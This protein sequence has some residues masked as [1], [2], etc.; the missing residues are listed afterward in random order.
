MVYRYS[1]WTVDIVVLDKYW[2]LTVDTNWYHNCEIV[3][4]NLEIVHLNEPSIPSV[5]SATRPSIQPLYG[6]TWIPQVHTFDTNR[7][8]P[9]NFP[10]NSIFP[11]GM[12]F[13]I[14]WIESILRPSPNKSRYTIS[15]LYRPKVNVRKIR[16]NSL[17][18][19]I[20][21]KIVGKDHYK[22]GSSEWNCAKLL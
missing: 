11:F 19:L 2:I 16:L 14:N 13:K 7:M 4:S 8:N 9:W 17:K 6:C 22:S 1:Q 5:Q 21:I 3:K 18:R 10:F 20:F 12:F 15:I